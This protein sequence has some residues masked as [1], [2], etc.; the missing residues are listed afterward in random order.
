MNKTKLTLTFSTTA[1]SAASLSNNDSLVG[2]IIPDDVAF[3]SKTLSVLVSYD[4]TTFF[5]LYDTNGNAASIVL[6]AARYI[7]FEILNTLG[8][9]A[10]KFTASASLDTK[11]ISVVILNS[12][13]V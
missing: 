3:N 2:I 4:E 6:G 10:I 7:P 8:V 5:P 9:K 13:T 1:S 11:T 12:Q